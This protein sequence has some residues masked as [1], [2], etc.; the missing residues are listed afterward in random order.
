MQTLI[1][2]GKC[3]CIKHTRLCYWRCLYCIFLLAYLLNT[4]PCVCCCF[5]IQLCGHPQALI[6]FKHFSNSVFDFGKRMKLASC[7]LSGYCLSLL[8]VPQAHLRISSLQSFEIF[9]LLTTNKSLTSAYIC[10]AIWRHQFKGRSHENQMIWL[11]NIL[12]MI[13]SWGEVH[14]KVIDCILFQM[15][16]VRL[17]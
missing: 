9:L 1:N 8:H 12:C 4:Q 17:F 3:R 10:G 11:A 2:T 14:S 15:N 5:Y 13:D 7:N 16:P 6:R